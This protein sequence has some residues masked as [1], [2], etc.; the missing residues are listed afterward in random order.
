[1]TPQWL[2]RLIDFKHISK[3]IFYI[4]HYFYVLYKYVIKSHQFTLLKFNLNCIIHIRPSDSIYHNKYLV[5]MHQRYNSKVVKQVCSLET[6]YNLQQF[7]YKLL[8]KLYRSCMTYSF[9]MI[10][11]P[12]PDC[13]LLFKPNIIKK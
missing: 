9:Y 8:K 7:H 12:G 3:I 1:M 10:I 4:Q 11:K 13:S 2:L 6:I 5:Y